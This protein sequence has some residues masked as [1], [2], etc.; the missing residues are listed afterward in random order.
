MNRN[1]SEASPWTFRGNEY[2]PVRAARSRTDSRHTSALSVTAPGSPRAAAATTRSVNRVM[3]AAHPEDVPAP[4]LASSISES[5][6]TTP[7]MAEN[8]WM[9]ALK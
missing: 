1:T 2:V 9:A 6:E 4:A 5:T 3:Y 7:G 8:A